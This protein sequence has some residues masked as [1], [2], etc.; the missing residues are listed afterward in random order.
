MREA[1]EKERVDETR[2]NRK[3]KFRT[4]EK[5]SKDK[6]RKRQSKEIEK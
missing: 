1:D 4:Q 3:G 5:G 2:Q 6:E